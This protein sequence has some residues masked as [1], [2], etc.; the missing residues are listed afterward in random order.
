VDLIAQTEGEKQKM[1]IKIRYHFRGHYIV[2]MRK[3]FPVH[4]DIEKDC[5]TAAEMTTALN[6]F[7]SEYDS[8]HCYGL[9]I[10]I[11]EEPSLVE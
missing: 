8:R 6:Q 3:G 11:S 9:T 1:S 4:H 10:G 2:E 7:T 5:E